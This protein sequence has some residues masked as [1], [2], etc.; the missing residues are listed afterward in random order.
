VNKVTLGLVFIKH[1]VSRMSQDS[2]VIIAT[3]NRLD[4]Q[5]IG[6]RVPVGG[7]NFHFTMLCKTALGPT[8]PPTQ[9]VPGVK[10]PE[11]EADPL[12]PS[13][14]EVKKNVA[15]YIHSPVHV[16]GVVLNYLSTGIASPFFTS[17]LL[18]ILIPQ[19]AP[20][21]FIFLASML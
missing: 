18:P 17:F 2:E 3:G 14:T 19:I 9:R 10:Q 15:L 1:F 4:Y 16:H 5:E 21:T 8:K 7:K 6:V 12:P 20:Y 13:N 11:S